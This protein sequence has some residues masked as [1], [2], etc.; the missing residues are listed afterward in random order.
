MPN[1]HSIT[2]VDGITKIKFLEKPTLEQLKLIIDEIFESYPYERRLWD[3]SEI[4]FDLSFSEIQSIAAYGKEKFI[5]PSK[6][7]IYAVDDLAFGEM[8]QFNVY[9]EEEG[10]TIPKTFRTE[11]EAIEWLNS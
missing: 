5:L 10:K 9:R 7:A 6:L 11:Q 3:L 1:T 8:H 2:H 4:K